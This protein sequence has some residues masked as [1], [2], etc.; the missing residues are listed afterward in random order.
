[1]GKNALVTRQRRKDGPEIYV[2]S[3]PASAHEFQSYCPVSFTYF[4]IFFLIS[5]TQRDVS[6]RYFLKRTTARSY[7]LLILDRRLQEQYQS[8]PSYTS[9]PYGIRLV[10]NKSDERISIQDQP[11]L[12]QGLLITA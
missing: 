11:G 1:M 4:S 7:N 8:Q 12:E 3:P 6:H 10:L 2:Q 5:D 9:I